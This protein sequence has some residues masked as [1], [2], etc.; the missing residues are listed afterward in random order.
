[1][2][3]FTLRFPFEL[4]QKYEDA[5]RDSSLSHFKSYHPFLI[6]INLGV[7]IIQLQQGQLTNGILLSIST[8]ILIIQFPIVCRMKQN[9]NICSVFVFNNIIMTVVQLFVDKNTS[10]YNNLYVAGCVITMVNI[11]LLEHYDFIWNVISLTI[12]I[13]I[14]LIYV[15]FYF[16]F[17]GIAIIYTVVSCYLY[18]MMYRKAYVRRALFLQ[19]ENEKEIRNILDEIIKD[20]YIH[21]KFDQDSFQFELKY[22]NKLAQ[23]RIGILGNQD[24]KDFLHHYSIYDSKQQQQFENQN[25]PRNANLQHS[26]A[27]DCVNVGQYLY[28]MMV[29]LKKNSSQLEMVVKDNST[30]QI[31]NVRCFQY[32]VIDK[33]II[34]LM[35]QKSRILEEDKQL[36]LKDQEI[37]LLTKQLIKINTRTKKQLSQLCSILENSES[38]PYFKI[39]ESTVNAQIISNTKIQMILDAFQIYYYRREQE[40]LLDIFP[41]NQIVYK[42][43]T[44]MNIIAE[45]EDKQITY[46]SELTE[47]DIITSISHIFYFILQNLLY[48]FLVQQNHKSIKFTLR[49]IDKEKVVMFNFYIDGL[50]SLEFLKQNSF[51]MSMVYKGLQIIGPKSEI[52]STSDIINNTQNP[53][54]IQVKIYKNLHSIIKQQQ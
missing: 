12:V 39:N 42:C 29:A 26:A 5:T 21:F 37:K 4:E 52:I 43:L 50:L 22:A 3:K 7:A 11:T 32:S 2:N 18:I 31:Y 30:H 35:E 13:T 46:E 20:V 49:N 6:M 45:V 27:M 54:L 23:Q 19:Y 44:I 41:I 51:I 10:N 38:N 17:D 25:K 33:E 24:L 9:K 53:Y 40:Q 36:K 8:I 14:R 15:I 16:K 47:S 28:E 1:M 34:M 48:L